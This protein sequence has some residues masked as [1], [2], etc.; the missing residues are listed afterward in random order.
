MSFATYMKG[1]RTN[2]SESQVNMAKILEISVTAIKLIENGDTKFPSGKVLKK[3][4]EYTDS[5]P[6]E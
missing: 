2:K 3:L 6:I 4:C 1:L 5:S